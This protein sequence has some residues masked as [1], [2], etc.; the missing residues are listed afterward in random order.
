M[1]ERQQ[2]TRKPAASDHPLI[3]SVVVNPLLIDPD[4]VDFVS[5]ALS[6][7]VTSADTKGF[8][9]GAKM[10]AVGDFWAGGDNDPWRPYVVSDGILQIPIQ[11]VL[12]NRVSYQFGRWA[13]GYTYIEK[14]LLRG[15]EDD[16][17]KGIALVVDSPGG[18]VAGCF[19]LA[20]KIFAA[21][22]QKPIKAFAAD[23][24]CSA[25]FALSSSARD[26]T[27]TRS[28][29]VGS[30]GVVTMHVDYSEM[31]AKD[32]VKITF[33][34][35]G[36]HKVD[37]NPY[38]A[39]PEAVKARIQERIDKTYG[40]F[41]STVARN[42]G[43]DEA[44]V[45][46]TKALT[47]DAQDALANG[48][49]DK[50][51]ALE[52]E[53]VVFANEE[54][55][56]NEDTMTAFTQDQLDKAVAEARVAGENAGKTLGATEER[57]RV[58]AIMALDEAKDRP[59]AARAAADS[60]LPVDVAKTMLGK[61][62]KEAAEAPAATTPAAST[63]PLDIAMALTNGGAQVGTLGEKAKTETPADFADGFFGSIG[64][65]AAAHTN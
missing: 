31:L 7:I 30:V 25:A 19:E 23:L 44:A 55:Q 18:E 33:V 53:M 28:G 62:P 15:L 48:F 37:G 61:L 54:T 10:A 4:A 63:N 43:I 17:V 42:R 65:P 52:E 50:I 26:I 24:A 58:T 38:E 20:D 56:T 57:T 40:V 27:I 21:R 32:G 47:Y 9:A 46:D 60:G 45:R 3:D 39:L 13:T 36:E 51:G 22:S 11:G 29:K 8:F 41:T 6:H 2:K 5:S 16:N 59:V 1:T 49:A 12:L 34:F 14:A 35:A 64:R